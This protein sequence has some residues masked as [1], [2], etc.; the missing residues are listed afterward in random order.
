MYENELELAKETAVKAG[1]I[2]K[3]KSAMKVD[4]EVGKDI[5]LSSDKMSEKVII[6]ALKSTGYPILSEE[7]GLVEGSNDGYTWIIDP[8]DGTANYSR[9]IND[10]CCTSIALWK[11]GEPILG[12]VNRF[13]QNELYYGVVGDGAWKNGQPIITSSIAKTQK[14]ILATGFPVHRDYSEE[15]LSA[16]IQNIQNFKKIRMFGAAAVMGVLVAE[17][18]IDVYMEDEIMLWD[19]AASTAIVKAAGGEVEVK[20]LKENKCICRLFANKQLR[21]DYHA[22]SI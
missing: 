13:F 12:V 18:K 14:A 6:E 5:K 9:G 4:L 16:F 10:M 7:Y 11:N 1:N 20:Q 17:G 19:I 15:S 21:E 3:D 8:L 22:D 2:L